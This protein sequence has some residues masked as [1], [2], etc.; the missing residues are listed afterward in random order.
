MPNAVER[1]PRALGEFN[2]SGVCKHDKEV[3]SDK[4]EEELP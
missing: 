2:A 4:L 3:K 1:W